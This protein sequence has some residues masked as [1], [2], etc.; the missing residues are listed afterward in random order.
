MVSLLHYHVVT[1]IF[2]EL[3][4]DPIF[5]DGFCE[6]LFGVPMMPLGVSVPQSMLKEASEQI[7]GRDSVQLVQQNHWKPINSLET[8]ERMVAKE[9]A[10]RGKQLPMWAG[11]AM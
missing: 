11:T 6:C 5:K 3:S 1:N 4:N 7:T 2:Q 10:P 8:R 9:Q